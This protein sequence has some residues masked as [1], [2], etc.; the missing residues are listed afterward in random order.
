M[1]A[2]LKNTTMQ[3]NQAPKQWIGSGLTFQTPG[4]KYENDGESAGG[5]NEIGERI[6]ER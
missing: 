4:M 5:G 1:M 2:E 3:S 6:G